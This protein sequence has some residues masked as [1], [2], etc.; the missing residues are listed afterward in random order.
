[1]ELSPN[2]NRVVYFSDYE[3]WILYMKDAALKRKAG[4]KVLLMRLSEKIKNL[5]WI[6]SDYLIFNAGNIVKISEIDERDKTNVIDIAE[7]QNPESFWSNNTKKLYILSEGN[8]Y[9]SEK[10]IQ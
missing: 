4:E 5:H 2:K 7:Y 3:I 9:Q 6:N 10:L 1:M 8:L